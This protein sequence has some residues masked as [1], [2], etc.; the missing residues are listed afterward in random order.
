MTPDGAALGAE[1][2][3][4]Q[5]P[6][7]V[8]RRRALALVWAR[9]FLG[10]LFWVPPSVTWAADGI[11]RL[12]LIGSAAQRGADGQSSLAG[13]SNSLASDASLRCAVAL[14]PENGDSSVLAD[15]LRGSD[16]AVVWV[17]GQKLDSAG[18]A[19]LR[20]IV[21]SGRG[22]VFIGLG[23]ETWSDWPE[24]GPDL[25]GARF[26][27]AFSQGAPIRIIN[28]FPHP[29]F[30]GVD[31]FDVAQPINR[32]D[33]DPGSQVIMEGTVGEETVPMGWVQRHGRGR[34]V[35]FT[36][37][38]PGLLGDADF[39][40]IVANSVRW[41]ARRPVPGAQTLVQ[42]TIMA[43]ALPGAL[44]ICFP[45]GPSLCYDTVRGGIN[46]IWDGDFVD[47]RPWW[48]ARHGE[49]LRAFAAR[50][51]GGIIYRDRDPSPGVHV[52]TRGDQSSY[53]F[54]GYR[55]KGDGYP[56]LHYL[57]GGREVTEELSAVGDGVGVVRTFRV[58][59][60]AAPL[61]LKVNGESNAVITVKGAERDGN[62]VHFDPS[63]EGEF[64]VTIR[65]GDAAIR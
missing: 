10:L 17:R 9:L 4:L 57:V 61:W 24:F 29:I 25:G 49:P 36:C 39:Q 8:S 22:L 12:S 19:A 21:D 55:L 47:L 52:G 38:D 31:H 46:Y 35:A 63:S 3:G 26:R 27:G 45:E 37:G 23:P 2:D 54:R 50:F 59:A 60:G 15:A 51:S 20:G 16:A 40:K 62:L 28:L 64:S 18:R 30:T 14:L 1:R 6:P 32:T 56:E 43:D 11:L 7:T 34:V 13:M 65:M 53:H 5:G 58:S 44:A 48:T 33:V 42:R 41:A